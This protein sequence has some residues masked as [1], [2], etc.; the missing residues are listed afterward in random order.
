V[1]GIEVQLVEFQNAQQ[2][3]DSLAYWF[4]VAEIMQFDGKIVKDSR[5]AIAW[6]HISALAFN[7]CGTQA[8]YLTSLASIS[9][10]KMGSV[11]IDT[12]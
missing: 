8:N 3:S 5:R 1:F 6:L 4:W 10:V 11:R 9:P 7:K 12:Q 2:T